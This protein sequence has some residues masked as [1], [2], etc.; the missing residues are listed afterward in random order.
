MAILQD[1]ISAIRT[2][3]STYNLKS[4]AD[5]A[6]TIKSSDPALRAVLLSERPLIE[7]LA[8]ARVDEIVEELASTAGTIAQVIPGQ[9]IYLRNAAALL[10]VPAELTRLDKEVQKVEKE[11]ESLRGRLANADFV[12]RAKPEVVEQS[13]A[14]VV[15]LE[16]RQSELAQHLQAIRAMA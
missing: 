10:D 5:T 13:R 12:A 1:A 2:L 16:Q 6:F 4:G 14:R 3:K 11:A 7:L 9:T 8:R 15:E